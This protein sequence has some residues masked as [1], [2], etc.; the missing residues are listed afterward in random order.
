[1]EHP[2]TIYKLEAVSE[3]PG[4]AIDDA[5]DAVPRDG[6]AVFIIDTE[7]L[8]RDDELRG[9]WLDPSCSPEALICQIEELTGRR[10]HD[11]GWAVI[12][13]VGLGPIMIDE[14]PSVLA[15]TA[16]AQSTAE[17]GMAWGAEEAPTGDVAPEVVETVDLD[18]TLTL[19]SGTSTN[20]APS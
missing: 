20:G 9:A 14:Q 6:P 2:S 7:A 12:D 10:S 17:P 8:D 4:T 18:T 1:M 16:F 19:M 11:G 3:E 15:L 5:Y 13:Q